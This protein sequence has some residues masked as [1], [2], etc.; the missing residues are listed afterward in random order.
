M[1]RLVKVGA[2]VISI[3]MVLT[4]LL[5]ACSSNDTKQT[6]DNSGAKK[7]EME[8][9]TKDTGSEKSKTSE[10]DVDYPT[11]P[12]QVVVPAGAGG[13]TDMNARLFGKYLEKELGQ[14]IVVVNTKGSGGVVG[15]EKV[16][17]SDP[18]G[19]TTLFFHVEN[20]IPKIAGLI[21][22][23]YDAFE[24]AGIGVID[25][26]TVIATHKDSPYKNLQE[27][28]DYAKSHPGEVEFGMQVGGY[29]NL[30]G[31]ALEEALGVD[32][33]LV[34]IGGNAAK[35]A[36]LK[37]KQTD[38]INTQ[39]GLTKDYFETGDF[40]SLGLTSPERN[41]LISDVATTA[42]QGYPLE[43]NKFFFYAM[44]EGTPKEIVNKFSAA[45]KKVV[46]NPEYQAEAKKIFVTPTYMGPEDAKAYMDKVY[47]NLAQYKDL[48][49]ATAN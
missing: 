13:D 31:I 17:N 36:A 23:D 18:D 41:P 34:D 33:N 1:K 3:T 37:G 14:P 2:S 7:Q 5:T 25:N 48:F 28:V 47:E 19:Y 11:K 6:N 30:V 12:I 8:N 44:P 43:F 21:D 27:L 20:M 35:T 4:L 15:M 45:M 39:Y 9:D 42:E 26:T 10:K 29:P 46:Q 38:V 40:V 16:K 24:L 22:Y 49:M 32:F